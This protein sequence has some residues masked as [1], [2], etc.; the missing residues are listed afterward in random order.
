MPALYSQMPRPFW[1]AFSYRLCSS[2]AEPLV[3]FQRTAQ[4]NGREVTLRFV[5]IFSDV[6]DYTNQTHLSMLINV[7]RIT[8][9]SQIGE[10][11][12]G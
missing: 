6:F 3:H 2:A 8:R 10:I 12:Q 1:Q 4:T 9:K 7:F 11:D 5:H